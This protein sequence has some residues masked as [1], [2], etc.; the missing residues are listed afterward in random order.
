MT[1]ADR[2]RFVLMY[3]VRLLNLDSESIS[4]IIR[5]TVQRASGAGR[6]LTNHGLTTRDTALSTSF[7]IL[8][9]KALSQHTCTGGLITVHLTI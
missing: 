8:E 1:T 5:S 7:V 3:E 6:G 4:V 9:N 2:M